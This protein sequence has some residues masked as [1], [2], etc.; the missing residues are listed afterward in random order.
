MTTPTTPTRSIKQ[1][2]QGTPEGRDVATSSPCTPENCLPP[3]L[4]EGAHDALMEEIQS[5]T[6]ENGKLKVSNSIY[7][8]ELLLHIVLWT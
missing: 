4:A 1:E 6:S 8:G 2:S 3:V 5:L 7:Q